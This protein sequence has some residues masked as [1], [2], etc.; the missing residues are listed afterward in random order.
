MEKPY[1]CTCSRLVSGSWLSS[2][3]ISSS[4]LHCTLPWLEGWGSRVAG[5]SW[6]SQDPREG[7]GT[8]AGLHLC[9]VLFFTSC[10]MDCVFRWGWLPGPLLVPL[11]LGGRA[12]AGLQLKLCWDLTNE[13]LQPP[14][15]PPPHLHPLL[16]QT[17][18]FSTPLHTPASC[19]AVSSAWYLLLLPPAVSA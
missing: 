8:W 17:F 18:I 6:A 15:W 12:V 7:R 2:A 11:H 9:F 1:L 4:A 13:P 19:F 3:F 14:P 5:C 16:Y 10:W